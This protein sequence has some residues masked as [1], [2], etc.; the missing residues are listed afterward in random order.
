MVRDTII[1][2]LIVY[3]SANAVFG[4]QFEEYV[5]REALA[6]SPQAQVTCVDKHGRK[7]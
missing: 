3:I 2:F 1:L 5:Q 6:N 4:K 7:L